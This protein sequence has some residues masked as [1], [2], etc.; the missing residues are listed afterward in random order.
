MSKEFPVNENAWLQTATRFRYCLPILAELQREN[1]CKF[2]LLMHRLQASDRA[3]RAGLDWLIDEGW[4]ERNHG[5]GHPSRPEYILTA[6]GRKFAIPAL[7]IWNELT[8]WSCQEIAFD[9]WSLKILSTIAEGQLRFSEV[10]RQV[11]RC[12]PRSLSLALLTLM[13]S[14]LVART[15]VDSAPPTATYGLTKWGQRVAERCRLA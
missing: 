4:V 5:Y 6:V 2:V 1:G 3:I 15:V 12:T 9:R 13:E 11:P 8:Q 7:S 10:R 14:G